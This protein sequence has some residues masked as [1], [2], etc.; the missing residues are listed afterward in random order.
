MRPRRLEI[1][2]FGPFAGTEKI[3][4][5]AL[6]R[7]GLFLVSGPTGGGKT[8]LLDAMSYALYGSVPGARR[9]DRLRSDHAPPGADTHVAFEFSIDG[10]DW[11][12]TR[13]PP[14]QR[15]KRRGAGTTLQKPTAT[16]SRRR[17]NA[18][19]PVCTG[20]E[21]VGTAV[22]DLL[23]L[24]AAQFSQVVVLPQGEVQSALRADARDRERL[25][26]SLFTTGRFAAATRWLTERA[27]ALEERA[28]RHQ[29]RL[30]SWR[31][32]AALRWREVAKEL[33]QAEE[34]P[35]PPETQ[36][37]LDRLVALGDQGLDVV[38]ARAK[39]ARKAAGRAAALLAEAQQVAA[40]WSRRR[41]AQERLAALEAERP[42]I[43]G[44]REQLRR[45]EAAAPCRAPLAAQA[46]AQTALTSAQ[47][48]YTTALSELRTLASSSQSLLPLLGDTV[49]PW[50]AGRAGLERAC[51]AVGQAQVRVEDVVADLAAV[52]EAR[53]EAR[54]LSAS[55]SEL[56]G[57]A[58]RLETEAGAA[59]AERDRVAG[60]LS[61]AMSA[62]GQV[63]SLRAD[64]RRLGR[65]AEAAA[66]AVIVEDAWRTAH[67]QSA[68]AV[69]HAQ[70]AE[71][72]HL[73]LL[74]RRVEG[75]AGELAAALAE[76]CPCAVC[77]ATAHPAPA[78]TSALVSGDQVEAA[79]EVT[80]Q[81]RAAAQ[82]LLDARDDL[83]GQLDV[84]RRAAGDASDDPDAARA[85]ADRAEHALARAETQAAH[86]DV[87]A[88]QQAALGE[89][90]EDLR[91]DAAERRQA[92]ISLRARAA[93][94]A[95][96]A[97]RGDQAVRRSLGTLEPA[98][99]L[100][101]LAALGGLLDLAVEAAAQTAAAEAERLS[102]GRALAELLRQQGFGDPAEARSALLTDD[103]RAALAKRTAD[104]ERE[105]GIVSAALADPEL[106]TLGVDSPPDVE[107]L[108]EAAEDARRTAET[109]L[110]RAATVRMAVGELRRL[111][112]DHAA[113]EATLGPLQV[114]A[115]RVRHLAEV[116][117]GT[118]NP[119]RMSLERYVLAAFLEEITAYASVRLAAM[120]NGRYTLRHTDVRG[121]GN[122]PSGLSIVVGDAFT[123]VE[124]EVGS[125]SGG[126]T[127]QASLALALAVADTVQAHAGG[128]RLDALF[129]DEGFGS[130]DPDALEQA[131]AELDRLREG[132][133]LVGV[134]SHVAALQERIP[135]QIRVRPTRAGSTVDVFIG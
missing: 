55:A 31:A 129:I 50:F 125:L 70:S 80:D 74:R 93:A 77:G 110:E 29:D 42:V 68:A 22:R 105:T 127:F 65:M 121:K 128:T 18:W 82:D 23:G 36:T 10:S 13:K 71:R 104:H 49:E 9:A 97:D 86:V 26:S 87:L 85:A 79:A 76:G 44:L 53:G 39:R 106:V 63:A 21:E 92:A 88:A 17:E 58:G 113:E 118:G 135:A 101:G 33:D 117:A 41:R 59:V 57:A 4:F 89:Q 15:A 94:R 116:C 32:E 45:A 69:D 54:G 62:S 132:G 27:R 122:G 25:L 78:H 46:T 47:E 108:A 64:G 34:P 120:S 16:L 115:V 72:A 123:G 96:E 134:I 14:H 112:V 81:L 90:I 3:D 109:A 28:G 38:Q 12:A 102:C 133:R 95:A 131:M 60:A 35:E 1:T 24:D 84:L 19:E 73:D 30:E 119:L 8:S 124:R 43:D 114:E 67:D 5:D 37:Q 11:R 130:L 75:M 100:A 20:V 48:R 2:A 66:E 83:A 56:E 6:A 103:E 7:S 52:E 61:E 107:G 91:A 99:A 98:A 40:L 111:A 126:E 51:R